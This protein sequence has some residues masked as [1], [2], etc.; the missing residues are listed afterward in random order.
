MMRPR[1]GADASCVANRDPILV[2]R[3]PRDGT[4]Y[5]SVLDAHDLGG[6]NF[7]YRLVARPEK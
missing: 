1:W 4:Y 7:G 2:V 5:V 3:L 6:P